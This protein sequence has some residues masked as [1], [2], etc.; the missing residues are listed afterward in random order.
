MGLVFRHSRIDLWDH[1]DMRINDLSPA[2]VG[3]MPFTCPRYITIN[4]EHKSF[5]LLWAHSHSVNI[6]SFVNKNTEIKKG[7]NS[8]TINIIPYELLLACSNWPSFI[9]NAGTFLY[10]SM[11]HHVSPS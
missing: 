10:C 8:I 4:Q 3:G 2:T 6:Q 11:P 1:F 7:E 5:D 9:L